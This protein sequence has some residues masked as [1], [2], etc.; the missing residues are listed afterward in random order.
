MGLTRF[1]ATDRDKFSLS[2]P[3]SL[4]LGFITVEVPHKVAQEART[5]SHGSAFWRKPRMESYS[6]WNL[7]LVG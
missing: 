7:R 4:P 3:L 2:E 6:C 5:E 1:D